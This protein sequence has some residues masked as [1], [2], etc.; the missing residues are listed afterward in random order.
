MY[1]PPHLLWL[2]YLKFNLL[3]VLNVLCIGLLHE[4]QIL[5]QT[6]SPWKAVFP[7][8]SWTPSFL[9]ADM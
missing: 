5:A 6:L 3:V 1:L 4:A 2:D 8:S 9:P 7:S